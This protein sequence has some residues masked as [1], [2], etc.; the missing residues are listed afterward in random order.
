[1]REEFSPECLHFHLKSRAAA[2]NEG[3]NFRSLKTRIINPANISAMSLRMLHPGPVLSK[4]LSAQYSHASQ[5]DSSPRVPVMPTVQL[6]AVLFS[7]RR[8]E[9]ACL[10]NVFQYP[11][12]R[13]RPRHAAEKEGGRGEKSPGG[14]GIGNGGG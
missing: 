12:D 5:R 4:L 10:I 14:K 6:T 7:A 9:V 8:T 11:R 1:M 13:D 3:L 2:L